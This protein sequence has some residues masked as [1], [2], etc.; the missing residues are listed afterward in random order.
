MLTG[1]DTFFSSLG[2]WG[3]SAT[4]LTLLVLG[5]LGAPLADSNSRWRQILGHLLMTPFVV[6]SLLFGVW[7]LMVLLT[8]EGGDPFDGECPAGV[9]SVYC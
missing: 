2:I 8:S 4:T 6:F 3:I 9:P 7:A 1:L 5:G